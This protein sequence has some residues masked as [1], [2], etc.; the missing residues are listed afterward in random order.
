MENL[1]ESCFA[2]PALKKFPIHT[3]EDT[4]GSVGAYKAQ[5]S[6]FT[7]QQQGIIDANF[8]KAA[9]Y[10]GLQMEKEASKPVHEPLVFTG[11]DDSHIQMSEISNIDELNKAVDFIL[12][13]R[14]SAKRRTLAEA[15]KYVLWS[16]SN[17]RVDMDTNKF[18]KIARIAGIGVGDRD[19]IQHALEKRAVDNL[20]GQTER[21]AFWKFANE[22]KALSD[23][24]FYRPE[25]LETMC[26]VID[27]IDYMFNGQHKQASYLGYPEDVVFAETQDDLLKQASDIY[28]IPAVDAAISKT[29]TLE[30]KNAINEFFSR[31]FSGQEPLDGDALFKKM[32]SLD[33]NTAKALLEH[34]K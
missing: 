29:A 24:D 2:F 23:S 18:R 25:N 20:L 12:T 4:I 6:L 27:N 16:A 3:R 10:Y 22:V 13:K 32:A 21:T 34:V 9:A 19:A 26:D 28:Y 17:T 7:T 33:E 30:R 1:H 15:A 31:H 14:A 11:D 5:R 8:T